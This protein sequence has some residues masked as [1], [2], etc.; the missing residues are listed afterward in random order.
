VHLIRDILVSKLCFFKFNVSCCYVAEHVPSQR[1]FAM[2]RMS[3]AFIK[4]Y[5]HEET[6]RREREILGAVDSP[7]LSKLVASYS[8]EKCLYILQEWCQVG[9]LP[10]PGFRFRLVT[11]N[12]LA[13]IN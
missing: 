11:W 13:V 8:G 5:R 7:F 2:K 9:L 3:R 10:L 1:A 12:I 6:A 4:K